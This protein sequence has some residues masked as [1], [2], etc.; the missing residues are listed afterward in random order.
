MKRY[1]VLNKGYKEFL[2]SLSAFGP[3]LLMII[4][5]AFFDDA[6]NPVA[7]ITA[8]DSFPLQAIGLVPLILPAI[9]PII[10]MI[11]KGFDGLIDV[12]LAALTDNLKTK[13]GKRRPP[14]LISIIPM[15]VSFVCLWIP[16]AGKGSIDAS[17]VAS[18]STAAQIVN[19]VWFA[20]WALV[21]FTFYTM[22]LI[23]YYGSISSVSADENQRTTISTY[24]SIFDTLAYCFAY[25][26]VPLLLGLLKVHIDVL[27]L[28]MTPI[29]LTI[30]I[31]L[32]LIKEG[33]KFEAKLKSQGYEIPV[34]KEEKI[35]VFRSFGLTFKNKTFVSWLIVNCCAFF[36]LQLFLASMNSLITNG[37]NFGENSNFMMAI[38]N[39]FAF[40]PVPLMLYFFNILRKKKGVRFAFQ[41]SLACFSVCILSFFFG[42]EFIMGGNNTAK[43]I[44]GI[45]GGVVGSWAIGSFFLMPLFVPSNI[46]SIEEKLAGK[47]HSAMFFAVQAFVT[48]IVGAVSGNLVFGYLR[49]FFISKA[50]RGIV[51]ADNVDLAAVALGVPSNTVFNLGN[52]LVPFIV[53]F[54]CILGFFLCYLMPKFITPQS[55]AKQLHLEDE[56]LK[57]PELISRDDLK[58]YDEENVGI[59]IAL[60]IFS[61]FIFNFFWGINI[62]RK[63]NKILEKK[64]KWWEII[65]MLIPLANT[66]YF[67][68][69]QQKFY[70]KVKD[71]IKMKNLAPSFLVL[72]LLFFN[73]F[74]ETHIQLQL[75]SYL[76]TLQPLEV[77]DL[78]HVVYE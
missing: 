37:M 72:D 26:L 6:I 33:D 74:S 19:T 57:H 12:P 25:A 55:V 24:K 73:A 10:W 50:T 32:F 54:F 61:A 18:I 30:C 22:S 78:A 56:L 67:Y 45:V 43:L 31:P 62:L 17:G 48:S 75:N 8:T 34:F 69:L 70:T 52:L 51:W 28:F 36:G 2:F 9:F 39:T 76:K 15:V 42:S 13:W 20:F 44:I 23:S 53:S 4:L 71:I 68:F 11:A 63:I 1:R 66:I 41:T 3:N 7:L 60:T 46:A 47:N 14:I 35:N 5:G 58:L 49:Q 59:N 38:L 29:M 40:A 64:T 16:V 77:S 65:L 27:V 21:F